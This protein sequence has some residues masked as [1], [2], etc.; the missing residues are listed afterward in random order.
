M[1]WEKPIHTVPVAERLLKG[2][3]FP[4]VIESILPSVKPV[5]RSPDTLYEV[6][7]NEAIA[8]MI[9][10]LGPFVDT[11]WCIDARFISERRTLSQFVGSAEMYMD[12]L[13]KSVDLLVITHVESAR[14]GDTQYIQFLLTHRARHRKITGVSVVTGALE[15]GLEYEDVL[16]VEGGE[17]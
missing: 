5:D 13:L 3:G 1:I 17:R 12:A 16:Q 10:G 6:P 2:T 15:E 14:P 8:S 7:T 4:R 11:A 9:R